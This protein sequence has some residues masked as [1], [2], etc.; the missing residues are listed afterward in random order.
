MGEGD[1]GFSKPVPVINDFYSVHVVVLPV[2]AARFQIFAL[3]G[4]DGVSLYETFDDRRR[5]NL[6]DVSGTTARRRF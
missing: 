2:V 1:G 5:I 4:S 6:V 3:V